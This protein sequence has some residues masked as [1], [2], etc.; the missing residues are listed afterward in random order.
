MTLTLAGPTLVFL[1]LLELSLVFRSRDF[2]LEMTRE[3]V[4]SELQDDG[5]VQ[6]QII[7]HPFTATDWLGF[8]LPFAMLIAATVGLAYLI[9]RAWRSFG[10]AA[11]KNPESDPA[12]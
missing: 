3:I 2:Y 6:L 7:E 4:M 12:P 11:S 5:S 8:T 10:E 9:R 1:V